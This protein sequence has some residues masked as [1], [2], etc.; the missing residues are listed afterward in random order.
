MACSCDSNGV[1]LADRSMPGPAFIGASVAVEQPR[2]AAVVEMFDAP[3]AK[4][5]PWW[6]I[7][8]LLLAVTLASGKR[9]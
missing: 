2:P 5:F 7:L 3:R 6:L 4:P 8:L 1:L 9:G